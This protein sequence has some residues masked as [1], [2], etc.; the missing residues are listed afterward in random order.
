M[1]DLSC[2]RNFQKN[3]K[4]GVGNSLWP[5]L[6]YLNEKKILVSM[7]SHKVE[8]TKLLPTR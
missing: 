2:K 1:F 4:I 7:N 6:T 8:L 3:L 5:S